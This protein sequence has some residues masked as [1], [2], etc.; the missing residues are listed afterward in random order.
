MRLMRTSGVFPTSSST[1][2]TLRGGII[3]PRI[4][5]R[6]VG[7]VEPGSSAASPIKTTQLS[8]KDPRSQERSWLAL[9]RIRPRG[10]AADGVRVRVP[11]L[12]CPAVWVENRS[13]VWGGERRARESGRPFTVLLQATGG[14]P[15]PQG[16]GSAR[17]QSNAL[18]IRARPTSEALSGRA[19][20]HR[21]RLARPFRAPAQ[22]SP[23]LPR[24]LPS[25]LHTSR[26]SNDFN[27]LVSHENCSCIS[28]RLAILTRLRGERIPAETNPKVKVKMCVTTRA[29]PWALVLRPFGA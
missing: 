25:L 27:G 15:E 18:G 10:G 28:P 9:V 6:F 8:R 3:K 4:T 14:P 2:L 22:I 21:T 1:E 19:K 23:P 20:A 11:L 29:L 7:W 26:K 17:A 5:G 13:R 24:A 12:A 16:G